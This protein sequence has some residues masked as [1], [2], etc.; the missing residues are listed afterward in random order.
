LIIWFLYNSVWALGLGLNSGNPAYAV[1]Q[2]YRLVLYATIAYF[3]TLAIFRAERHLPVVMRTLIWAGLIVST[4]Q[5]AITISGGQTVTE[6]IVFITGDA[7]GRTLRDVNVPLYFA[8]TALIFLGVAK[9][10]A[11]FILGKIGQLVWILVPVFSIAMVLSLTRTVWLSLAISVL[12]LFQYILVTHHST[13]RLARSLVLIVGVLVTFVAISIVVQ[14]FLPS[15][16]QS[17]GLTI[18][19]SLFSKDSTRYGRSEI[20]LSLLRFLYDSGQI[21]S[22][23]GFGNMWSGAT[24]IGPH[25]NLHNTYLAYMVIGGLPGLLLFLGIWIY[26]LIVYLC[27]LRRSVGGILRAFALSSIMNWVM[28]STLMFVMP[29]HWT[30]SA[31]FGLTLGIASILAEGKAN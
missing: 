24:R 8:G 27:L 28:I 7:I 29:P 10:R 21:W 16:Y 25:Y 9:M 15:V 23:M 13:N 31:L 4:W 26:P 20:I 3:T 30:E 14:T 17:V 2:E 6:E 22:G 1:L 5:L 19:L 12:L 18:D 11:P